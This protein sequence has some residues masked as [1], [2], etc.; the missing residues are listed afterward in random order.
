MA[1]IPSAPL[2]KT[3]TWQ[4]RGGRR[5]LRNHESA[6]SSSVN[7]EAPRK[8]AESS[9]TVSGHSA[10]SNGV[11]CSPRTPRRKSQAPPG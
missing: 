8:S 11:P 1:L 9:S 2:G 6:D 4:K 5:A 10:W 7:A 3:L